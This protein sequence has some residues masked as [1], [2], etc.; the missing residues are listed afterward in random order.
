MLLKVNYAEDDCIYQEYTDYIKF[1]I[2][3]DELIEH[4]TILQY[5]TKH[6]GT[7]S[8]DDRYD[9]RRRVK[10]ECRSSKSTARH[11]IG[12]H[13]TMLKNRDG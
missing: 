4:D 2:Q 13:T 10:R 8:L 3:Y 11:T 6:W 5:H 7:N 9:P 1:S 12:G